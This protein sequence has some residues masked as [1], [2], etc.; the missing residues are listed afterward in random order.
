MFSLFQIL[1]LVLIIVTAI[2]IYKNRRLEKQK[3][4]IILFVLVLC[5]FIVSAIFF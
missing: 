3:P 1:N 4:I 5:L 2:L